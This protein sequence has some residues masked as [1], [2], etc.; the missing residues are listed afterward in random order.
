[1]LC[2]CMRF[3]Q[4]MFQEYKDQMTML[5][6]SPDF[7]TFFS[8]S[9]IFLCRNITLYNAAMKKHVKIMASN[10]CYQYELIYDQLKIVLESLEVQHFMTKV[11]ITF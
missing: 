10:Q 3:V 11:A 8:V 4:V 5:T 7:N 2:H 1:M 6:N 9:P